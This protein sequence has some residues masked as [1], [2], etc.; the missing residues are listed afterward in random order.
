MV[1][2]LRFKAARLPKAPRRFRVVAP[3]GDVQL[4]IRAYDRAVTTERGA[5]KIL[6]PQDG[7]VIELPKPSQQT[8]RI[9][10]G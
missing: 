7:L 9:R 1:S 8:L 2:N 4:N 3:V 5:S 6:L 10:R